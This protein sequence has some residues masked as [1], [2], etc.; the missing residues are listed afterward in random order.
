MIITKRHTL[1]K[2]DIEEKQVEMVINYKYL[3]TWVNKNNDTSREIRTR[4]EIARQRFV[5]IKKENH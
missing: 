4:I 3:G 5:K 1:V 2:L